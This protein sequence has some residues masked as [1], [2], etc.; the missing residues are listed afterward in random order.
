[1]F[2]AE[3]HEEITRTVSHER[4]VNGAGLAKRFGVTMETIRRDLAVLESQ[5]KLRR[6]HGGA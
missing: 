4:R 5:G 6:V 2:A 3:R 1:M